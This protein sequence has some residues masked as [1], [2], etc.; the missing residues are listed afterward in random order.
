MKL[1]ITGGT[2]LIGSA[3]YKK[4]RNQHQ[5]V[6]LTR[7]PSKA[8]QN[9]GHDIEVLSSLSQLDDLNTFDGVIN[10]AGEPI[11]DKRWSAKQKEKIEQ[12]RWRITEDLVTLF[13]ASETPPSVLISGSAIGYYGRQGQQPVTEE[14][15]NVHDEFTHRLCAKWEAIAR[16]AESSQTRVCLLRTGVVLASDDGALPRIA[17]PIKFGLGGPIGDGQQQMSWIHIDDI[18]DIIH[19][20]LHHAE[21]KGPY[22][23]TAPYPASN[24]EFTRTLAAVMHRPCRLRVPAFVMRTLLGE[25]ADMLLTGQAVLPERIQESGF[26]YRHPR[27]KGALNNLC[28]GPRA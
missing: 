8:Y 22:N 7:S 10:L 6:V 9:L 27:L 19:W 11:A 12:S 14:R 3:L 26:Q 1:L 24:E 21:C 23:A 16:Q 28:R 4:L 25:M 2:G 20:L 13:K 5:L 17:R 18:V 15:P